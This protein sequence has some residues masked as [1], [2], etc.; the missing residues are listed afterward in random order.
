[1]WASCFLLLFLVLLEQQSVHAKDATEDMEVAILKTCQ[2]ISDLRR[3]VSSSP[4]LPICPL[5]LNG[6]AD[7]PATPLTVFSFFLI[8]AQ[9][10][11]Q[12]SHVSVSSP[13]THLASSCV[14]TIL[15]CSLTLCSLMSDFS[16]SS[17][18]WRSVAPLTC[19]KF[20]ESSCL[21]GL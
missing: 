18:R 13:L 10:P 8:S 17:I 16:C 15:D 1:M 4:A 5:G 3:E 19:S 14:Y 2:S 6:D 21:Y 12:L 9:P 7:V 20:T 11:C